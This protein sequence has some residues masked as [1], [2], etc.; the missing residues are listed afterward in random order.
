MGNKNYT[1]E[2][3]NEFML[4][5][6]LENLQ[7]M[8]LEDYIIFCRTLKYT[9][10]KR[11]FFGNINGFDDI[12][13]GI[14]QTDKKRND[15]KT[16]FGK[17]N[18]VNYAWLSFL[19]KIPLGDT[20]NQAYIQIRDQILNIANLAQQIAYTKDDNIKKN[21]LES[22]ERIDGF[23]QTFKWKIAFLYSQKNLI[24]CYSNKKLKNLLLIL[25]PNEKVK[26]IAEM[27]YQLIKIKN[28]RPDELAK[29]FSILWPPKNK[30]NNKN[31]EDKTMANTEEPILAQE[32]AKLLKNTKNLI[33]HGAPGT[34]K[35][36]LA[37]QI[38]QQMIFGEVKI[39]QDFT[40]EE[41]KKFNEQVE[42]VQF[43]PSYDYTDF[44]EGIRPTTDGK[45]NLEDGIFKKFCEKAI[46]DN[47]SDSEATDTQKTQNNKNSNQTRDYYRGYSDLLEYLL[48]L[49]DQLTDG[50]ILANDEL[51]KFENELNRFKNRVMKYCP[52]LSDSSQ[53]SA[54]VIE[55]NNFLQNFDLN[56]NF[57]EIR[58]QII[59]DMSLKL[60]NFLKTNNP[61]NDLY[62]FW[63]L[64]ISDL[65]DSP[66]SPDYE[67]KLNRVILKTRWRYFSITEIK[68][69]IKIKFTDLEKFYQ[70]KRKSKTDK[71]CSDI[72]NYL[73]EKHGL[74]DYN[75]NETPI[76]S[77]AKIPEYAKKKN[78]FIFIIDE[79]NRGELSKIFGELFFSIDPGYRGIKG[80]ILTQYA[81]MVT[82][83][84]KFDTELGITDPNTN[85]D[86][87]ETE[88]DKNKGN[89][90][91]FFV[92]E[93]V[94]IIGTMNDI[95]RSVESMDLA[96]RRRFTF[97]EIKAKDTQKNI[98]AVQLVDESIRTNA[99]EHMDNLNNA[100]WN[101]DNKTGELSSSDYHIGGAYFLKLNNFEGTSE[102]KF[103]KLWKYNLE[104]LLNEY[105]RGQYDAEKKLKTLGTAY[106]SEQKA[107]E[108]ANKE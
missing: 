67:F 84:N 64:L 106:R 23:A 12:F 83:P 76:E 32:C 107:D 102:E 105:L 36:Y 28:E 46:L 30:N 17:Y 62:T 61:K 55:L 34:G 41:K 69:G 48:W 74:K 91:H 90:G 33:L 4:D 93:N 108:Q 26:T 59:Q 2:N 92:P 65:Y 42:L 71:I 81:N 13:F 96:M 100:I 24:D 35:T 47:I 52:E 54:L 51:E 86:T 16:K 57:P 56:E 87:V 1:E 95:D 45:F 37:R 60:Y 25:A 72:I 97:F 15:D 73:K 104:P 49:K 21:L 3:Y 7:K 6:S 77:A 18:G 75:E 38:A 89:Y 40:E 63:P 82:K 98:L 9:S 68:N 103:Q 5:Y 10:K 94:Y 79:I 44:V 43:H 78:P 11:P 14:Y 29:A 27:Q 53:A 80:A 20:P 66:K 31:N 88:N 22:I 50:K 8:S 85:S 70:G 101:D 58:M 99:Q 39:E 19:G